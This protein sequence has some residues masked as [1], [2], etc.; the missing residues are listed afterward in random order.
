MNGM[1]EFRWRSMRVVLVVA[2]KMW[3]I[4]GVHVLQLP[5]SSTKCG[6]KLLTLC[7]RS[8][9]NEVALAF[10]NVFQWCSATLINLFVRLWNGSVALGVSWGVAFHGLFGTN[11]LIWFLTPFNGTWRR[12]TNW[13]G[14]FYWT[15]VDLNGNKLQRKQVT[16]PILT[17]LKIAT[18]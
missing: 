14:T 11:W 12:Y 8:L 16:N 17:L 6:I 4:C 3:N 10:G 1:G 18:S 13:C 7:G 15:M 2:R 5:T 9:P